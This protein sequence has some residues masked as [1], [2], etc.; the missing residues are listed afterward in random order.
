VGEVAVGPFDGR[1]V[2][3][4]MTDVTHELARQVVDR[5]EDPAGDHLA[6]D[7]AEPEF[8]PD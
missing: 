2:L 1:G 4:V 7:A 3:V 6:F 8:G 5:G